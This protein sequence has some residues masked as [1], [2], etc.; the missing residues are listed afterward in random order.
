MCR[1]PCVHEESAPG[2]GWEGRRLKRFHSAKRY[3]SELANV[4]RG[5]GSLL[6]LQRV[7]SAIL[8]C[9]AGTFYAPL[10]GA[11]IGKRAALGFRW[12]GGVPRRGEADNY[13]ER[14]VHQNLSFRC[15]KSGLWFQPQ[16]H[17]S[18][19][20]TIKNRGK[21]SNGIRSK[22]LLVTEFLFSSWGY[23]SPRK[24]GVVPESQKN[25][26]AGL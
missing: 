20:E 5:R 10:F 14:A 21:Q 11:I 22:H 26:K 17:I 16:C 1:A 24:G 7:C 25:W 18:Y 15:F 12:C 4:H 2:E 13:M 8:P 19:H 23:S 3:C 6:R 9:M